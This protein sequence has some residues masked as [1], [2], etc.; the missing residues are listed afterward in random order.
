M[1]FTHGSI[2]WNMYLVQ[3]MGTPAIEYNTADKNL[4]KFQNKYETI[5]QK[6]VV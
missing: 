4:G 1:T 3:W 5:P 6:K 2:D